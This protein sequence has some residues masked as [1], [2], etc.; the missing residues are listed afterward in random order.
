M[1]GTGLGQDRTIRAP[2]S[3]AG[4]RAMAPDFELAD[5]SGK[6]VRLSDLRG[7][8][9]LLDFWATKCGGCVEEIPGFIEVA[10]VYRSRGL[11][12]LGVSEDIVYENLSGPDQAWNQVRSFVRDHKVTYTV[13][14]D[15]RQVD[16]RYNITA[17]PLTY[18]VDRRGRIAAKYTGIVD[19]SNLEQNI[20]AL[21]R[22]ARE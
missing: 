13:V 7:Q 20:E 3:Q 1:T 6:T 22:E 16:R 8:V 19:R 15:D 9:V 10:T 14:L 11:A 2:L 21:L 18:L 5:T 4:A 17:L 12:A